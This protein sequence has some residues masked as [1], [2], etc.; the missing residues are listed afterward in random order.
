M[1]SVTSVP[2]IEWADAFHEFQLL[3]FVSFVTFVIFPVFTSFPALRPNDWA[4][5]VY[6]CTCTAPSYSVHGCSMS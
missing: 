4:V 5:A 3:C 6:S 2:I 1:F